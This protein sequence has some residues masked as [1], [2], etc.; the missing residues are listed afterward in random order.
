[1]V[2]PTKMVLSDLNNDGA[3]DFLGFDYNY[4]TLGKAFWNNK[5]AGNNPLFENAIDFHIG[6]LAIRSVRVADLNGDGKKDII[7]LTKGTY[8]MPQPDSIHFLE[9]TGDINTFQF[10]KRSFLFTDFE[11]WEDDLSILDINGDGKSD[12]VFPV[13]NSQN[14]SHLILLNKIGSSDEINVC[15]GQDAP[16]L[17]AGKNGSS[18]QWQSSS[19]SGYVNMVDGPGVEGALSNSIQ[20][21]DLTLAQHNLRIRCVV[22]GVPAQGYV[23]KIIN[24]WVG[25]LGENA[26]WHNPANW[27]CGIVPNETTN[28]LIDGAE[29]N[30]NSDAVCSTLQ[31]INNAKVNVKPNTRLAIIK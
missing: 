31:L 5:S 28:V 25:V 6:D 13:Y 7:I 20:L 11:F 21:S 18:Y 14:A 29:V 12:L 19:G 1:M 23:I 15:D 24:R 10:V 8:E 17:V 9:R 26:D 30:I 22:D 3:R 4:G 2:T 27:S 16:V